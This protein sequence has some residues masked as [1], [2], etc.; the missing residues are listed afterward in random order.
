GTRRT[1]PRRQTPATAN[2]DVLVCH[3]LIT[4]I[5]LSANDEL[6]ARCDAAEI[7]FVGV[8]R[9][10]TSP[11]NAGDVGVL[12]IDRHAHP[13]VQAKFDADIGEIAVLADVHVF[14]RVREARCFLIAVPADARPAPG[15][16]RLM[17]LHWAPV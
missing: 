12:C 16:D 14:A 7:R 2:D 8:L 10:T 1:A 13:A 11:E 15:D 6:Q 5:H 17:A 9:N 4:M 3:A